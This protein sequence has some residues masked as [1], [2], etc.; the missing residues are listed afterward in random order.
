LLC[1]A[2][3]E[4]ILFP[5]KFVLKVQQVP[6]S[7]PVAT[8][9]PAWA[10]RPPNPP[11]ESKVITAAIH[12][13]VLVQPLDLTL[14]SPR[15]SIVTTGETLL[16]TAAGQPAIVSRSVGKGRVFLLGFCLQ[17]TYFKAWQNAKPA[18]REQLANL[19][20]AM[21][22]AAGVQAHVCSSS[23]DIEAS[24]RA[25]AAEGFLFIINH[26]S[27]SPETTVRL[28]DLDFKLFTFR[29]LKGDDFRGFRRPGF[30]FHGFAIVKS[31]VVF[32]HVVFRCR[33]PLRSTETLF[34]SH[35]F[36][37]GPPLFSEGRISQ[38]QPENL[39]VLE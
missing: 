17:D 6:L 24:V 29:I 3:A 12:G 4:I 25:N 34:S 28:R 21:T 35:R 23:P 9:A 27:S 11:N 33:Q 26:E 8:G 7:V 5:I 19:L 14:A 36:G 18:A 31:D 22:A 13:A 15:P 2:A 16:K 10:N 1:A 37:P 32:V 20:L 38:S 30:N 39:I